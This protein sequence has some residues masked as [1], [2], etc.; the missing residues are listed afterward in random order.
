MI[1]TVNNVIISYNIHVR[2]TDKPAE[3]HFEVTIGEQHNTSSTL[4]WFKFQVMSLSRK[5]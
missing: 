2:K 5:I 3:G 1:R 4:F